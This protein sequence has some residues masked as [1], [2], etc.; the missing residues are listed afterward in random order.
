MEFELIQDMIEPYPMVSSPLQSRLR[1]IKQFLTSMIDMIPLWAKVMY[2]PLA[3]GGGI[4]FINTHTLS[5][6]A[7]KAQVVQ[8]LPDLDTLPNLG[9]SLNI[10]KSRQ[11]GGYDLKTILDRVL[12]EVNVRYD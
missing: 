2:V 10:T 9:N 6:E 5:S 12:D 4:G 3:E 11:G 8:D 1:Y 7:V